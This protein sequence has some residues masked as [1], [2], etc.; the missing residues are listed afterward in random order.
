MGDVKPRLAEE[1]N[2]K[3]K[4]WKLTEINETSQCRSL[5]LQENL[6]I[7][8]VCY[9]FAGFLL[10]KYWSIFFSSS[11]LWNLLLHLLYWCFEFT[12]VYTKLDCFFPTYTSCCRFQQSFICFY[13]LAFD[14]YRWIHTSKFTLAY[15]LF[16]VLHLFFYP[17]NPQRHYLLS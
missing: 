17:M 13:N 11:F 5:R 7:T 9:L 2:D 8:K 3:S 10:E 14:L 1:T 16:L 6:R 4:I 12:L 15:R